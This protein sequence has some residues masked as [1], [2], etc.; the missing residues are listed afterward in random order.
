MAWLYLLLAGIFEII[1]ATG[2]KYTEGFT[3]LGPSLIT[4]LAIVLSLAMLGLSLRQLPLSTAY[5]IWSGIGAIGTVVIGAMIFGEH[6][7]LLRVGCISLILLGIVGL[8]VTS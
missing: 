2:L 5:S 3:R 7:S 6:L 8:K 4:A 1:W